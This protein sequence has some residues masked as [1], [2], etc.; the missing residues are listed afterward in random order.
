MTTS[1]ARYISI[2]DTAKL[3]RKALKVAFP[4]TTFSV[5]KD[6]SAI[7]I[8]W[9]DGPTWA[10]VN[11]LGQYFCGTERDPLED[12][13][14]NVQRDLNG[15]CVQFDNAYVSANR[16][17][18]ISFRMK[19]MK[20]TCAYFNHEELVMDRYN[21]FADDR[22]HLLGHYSLVDLIS[23]VM[24]MTN[25]DNGSL[26]SM[27]MFPTV[28]PTWMTDLWFKAEYPDLAELV[29]NAPAQDKPELIEEV[30]EV[31]DVT[32]CV[33]VSIETLQPIVKA[34]ALRERL[35]GLNIDALSPLEAL[36]A[37]YELKRLV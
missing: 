16:S 1:Q 9:T 28:I 30:E 10:E 12:G 36:T 26:H 33:K 19:V 3:V 32:P 37:L 7:A 2:V 15:E 18:S 20:A 8:A 27:N 29:E 11:Q 31:E 6:N 25:A 23:Q 5:R 35:T 34:D 24:N 22:E 13:R 17:A 21:W 4:D 14:R